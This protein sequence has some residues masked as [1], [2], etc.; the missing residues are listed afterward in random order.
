MH[1]LSQEN[2][3]KAL[4][5]NRCKKFWGGKAAYFIISGLLAAFAVAAI[6]P[7]PASAN[8]YRDTLLVRFEHAI[9][10]DPISNV[11]TGTT[12]TATPNVV[13]GISPAGQIWRI[14]DLDAI[15]TTDSHIRVR[16][17]GLLLG[18]GNGIGTNGG[19]SV[20]ATLFCGAAATATASSTSQ[21]GVALDSDGDFVIDDVLS[22]LPPTSCET[23][24]LLIRTAAGAHPWFAAG[25]EK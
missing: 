3:E 7:L 14:A 10:V 8:G 19:Q 9:G 12:T 2:K 6:A 13:R 23:P 1:N 5:T 24:V 21:P 20:F 11:V 15:V 17:R 16:G 25:I 18:G 22:P 4:N